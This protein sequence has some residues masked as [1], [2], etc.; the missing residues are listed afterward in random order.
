[1]E[2]VLSSTERGGNKDSKASLKSV[3]E[4]VETTLG[5]LADA[6]LQEQPPV[7]RKKLEHL[8]CLFFFLFHFSLLNLLQIGKNILTSCRSMSSCT[9]ER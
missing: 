7:R 1:M 6:V 8:V 4:D 5:I 3:L 2:G 9:S